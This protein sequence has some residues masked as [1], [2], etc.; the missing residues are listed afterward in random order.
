MPEVL[1]GIWEGNDEARGWLEA[2]D[3][4]NGEGVED[5]FAPER[6]EPVDEA[7]EDGNNGTDDEEIVQVEE[8]ELRPGVDP[9][10]LPR[11]APN[12]NDPFLARIPSFYPGKK[13]DIAEGAAKILGR[14]KSFME[15]F[16]EA[17]YS[18]FRERLPYYPFTSHSEW[19]MAEF[20]S[21]SG[22]SLRAIDRFLKLDMV[23]ASSLHLY[24]SSILL[25]CR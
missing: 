19:E 9:A 23:R 20:L 16:H 15:Q 24:L 6:T 21:N 10:G 13:V 25:F 17:K 22:L 5:P 14:G 11:D 8:D 12:I 1:Q 2:D 4:A 7:P 3:G 18:E